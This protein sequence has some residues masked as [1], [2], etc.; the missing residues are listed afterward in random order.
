MRAQSKSNAQ[1]GIKF[2]DIFA[3]IEAKNK[4]GK[5][6]YR[7]AFK[8]TKQLIPNGMTN[9]PEDI[10]KLGYNWIKKN[11]DHA[12]NVLFEIEVLEPRPGLEPG[13]DD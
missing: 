8:H 12:T 1:E 9:R 11:P 2:D 5:L 4:K 7:L 13:F 6:I 3:I 10:R